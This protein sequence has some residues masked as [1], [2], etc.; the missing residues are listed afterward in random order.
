MI[1]PRQRFKNFLKP[2]FKTDA[3]NDIPLM[4]ILVSKKKNP[5]A[6][7]PRLQPA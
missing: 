2:I 4:M 7:L 1:S 6:R 3:R 5:S